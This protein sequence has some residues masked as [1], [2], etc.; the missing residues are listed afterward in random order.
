MFL[1]PFQNQH[2]HRFTKE[3]KDQEA[4]WRKRDCPGDDVHFRG[5]LRECDCG[6]KRFKVE[7]MREVEVDE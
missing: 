2:E 1:K 4:H 6:A 5:T 7:G 3:T